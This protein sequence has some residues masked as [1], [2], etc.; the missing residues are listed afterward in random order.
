MKPRL[1]SK[2]R[3]KTAY[4]C[5]RK[6]YWN[7][8]PEYGNTLRES[9]FMAALAEGGF[10]V[11][12]L[13][14]L[15]IPGGVDLDG[16]F[17]DEAV[18]KTNELLKNDKVT[19]YEAALQV[20]GYLVRVDVLR[21]TGTKIDLIEV[22]SKSY[23]FETPFFGKR[24]SLSTD[25][26]P[27]LIDIAF[28]AF[29]AQ[30]AFPNFSFVPYLHL[31][32]KRVTYPHEGFHQ[33]FL[34]EKLNNRPKV[35]VKDT[36]DQKY[37]SPALLSLVNVQ[38]EVD[39]L[40]QKETFSTHEPVNFIQYAEYLSDLLKQDK[41]GI[42]RANE[43]CKSCEFNISPSLE[44]L[45]LKNG[46][47]QCWIDAGLLDDTNKDEP[48][49]LKLWDNRRTK[50][51]M[52]SDIVFLKD[53]PEDALGKPSDTHSETKLGL[54]RLERQ[55][56]QVSKVRENDNT[57]YFDKDYL[58]LFFKGLKFP[59]HCID[60]ETTRTP[61][62]FHKNQKPNEQLAYQF[63][64]HIIHED[65]HI[66][67]KTQY[68]HT[69]PGEF[70][71][72]EF[73]RS[74]MNALNKDQ[75]TVFRY[76]HHENSVLNDIIR[77]LQTFQPEGFDELC[78]FIESI[79]KVGKEGDENYRKGDR[80]MIDLCDVVKKAYYHPRM[81]GSN[82]IKVVTPSILSDS[83]FLQA[84][85]EKPIYGKNLEIPSL[86]FE[87]TAWVKRDTNT[88]DILD[89]Y[90][91]LPPVEIDSGY[92][93]TDIEMINE[94]G[95]ASIAWSRMQFTE[96]SESE[97]EAIASGLLRYCELDT[98]SMVWLLEYFWDEIRKS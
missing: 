70:P 68:L 20:D 10:Q 93:L 71:N 66:E 90:K 38:K 42:V 31:I 72:F 96:M 82:S 48:T 73:A 91:N 18:Q 33:H 16:I 81:G 40:I 27:Y 98:L 21:K 14:K 4:E 24:G 62:P 25:W 15:Y 60:F 57:P 74:L 26:E 56:L 39:F 3:F 75:G 34:I 47:K 64:H 11:G 5:P 87:N 94:G 32:D 35:V 86:N 46:F 13:A 51:M 9:E 53:I 67:H 63:S 28:Q 78:F 61:I 69:A 58:K 2:S 30:R 92:R 45:G 1:L 19:I 88:L 44:K 7:E 76:S 23:D 84:K 8:H 22:K 85:Y 65:W 97:R 29:V 89:P 43:V 54:S 6:L 49:I 77:Q 52:G 83:K 79:T 37:L 50:N 17:G 41:P 59:L 80:S 12:A 55:W 36:I 95:G